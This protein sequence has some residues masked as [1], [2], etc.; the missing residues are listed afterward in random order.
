VTDKRV[1]AVVPADPLPRALQGLGGV[2]KTAVA[3]EYAHRYL[4][5]YDLVWWI[6]S[7]QLPLVRSSLAA[8]AVPLGLEAARA[9]GIDAAARAVLDA[10]RRGEPFS[11][12]LLIYDNADE[13]DELFHII[14]QGP[15]DVLITSRDNRWQ[16]AVD[17]IQLN[18]FTR[19]ESMEFLMKRAPRGLS[20]ADADRLADRLGDL[21]LALEQAGAVQAETGMPVEEYLRLLDEHAT[22]IMAEGKSVE[23]PMSMT[24]AWKLSVAALRQQL[25][26][27]LELLRCCAFFGPDPIPRDVF[28]RGTQ[29]TETRMGG[30]GQG[31]HPAGPGRP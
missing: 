4:A 8:L 5:D 16:S 26:Q 24:A 3:I 31:P 25:P 13:P 28:R 18:V 7:D 27:A 15:G 30:I 23:Y 17:T 6:Q 9:T 11:R 1:T 19:A 29:A 22:Q 10:L 21:P 14:P 2:G 12:W 20:E